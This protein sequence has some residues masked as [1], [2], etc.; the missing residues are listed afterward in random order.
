MMRD[1]EHDSGLGDLFDRFAAA[2]GARTWA[3]QPDA[4]RSTIT[5]VIAQLIGERDRRPAR[6]LTTDEVAQVLGV[7]VATVQ[8]RCKTGGIHATRVGRL[9]RVAE[10]ELEQW[11]R[12]GRR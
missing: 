7:H 5:A 4:V 2:F 12:D 9:W 6:L 11:R 3:E 8:R 1:D 10:E